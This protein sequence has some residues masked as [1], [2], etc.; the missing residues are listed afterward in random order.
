MN[1]LRSL[2]TWE[3]WQFL[4]IVLSMSWL[5]APSLNAHLSTKITFISQFEDA[6]QPWA[7]L[8]RLCD[9]LAAILL[10]LAVWA[11]Y[12]RKRNSA[13]DLSLY[14]PSLILLAIVALGSIIDVAFPSHCHGSGLVCL[15]PSGVSRLIHSGESVI[16]TLALLAVNLLWAVKKIPWARP[17]LLIQII[18]IVIFIVSQLTNQDGNTLTQFVYQVATAIW[19]A[20]IVPMLAGHDAVADRPD[21]RRQIALRVITAWILLGGFLAILSSIRNVEEISELSSAY[22]GNNTAWLS[23]HGVA[24]GIVLMY[25]SRHLWRGEYRAWQ[26]ASLLLWLETLKYA[27]ISPHTELTLLYG[28]TAAMLFMRRGLF[29]RMTSTE[30]LRDRLQK[31]AL[32]MIAVV[33]AL[34]VGLAAFRFKHHQDLDTLHISASHFFRHLFLVDA[35]NDLGP[36]PRRLLGQVLNVAGL[37]LLFAILISLFRPHKPLLPPANEHDRARLLNLLRTSSNSSED[38]FKYWPQPKS[39]FWS[40]DRESAV[41]YRVVGNVAFALADP[42]AHSNDVRQRTAKEFLDYCRRHGWRACFLMVQDDQQGI[43]KVHDYK[44]FRIGASAV[45]DVKEF[46]TETV[47]NKW[48]RWVLNKAKK[49]DWQYE[50]AMPPHDARL[51]SQLRHVSDIWL[52]RQNH[53]ERGFAL[54]YFDEAYLQACRLHLLRHDDELIAFANELPT[55]NNLPTA[56]IDLMRFLPD[57]DHAMPTLLAGTIQQLHAEGVKRK[58]DLGFVPLA[59]PTAR[60][61]QVVRRLGQSLMSESVSAQGLEQFKNKFAPAWANNYIAFDGDWIDL[62][63][64]SRQLDNLLEVL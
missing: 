10:G 32:V 29:D 38:Y 4:Y 36:M 49:Q 3:R 60:T 2:I 13:P 54:G 27:L 40:T 55:F 45:V 64:I 37:T 6:G 44:L 16:T 17:V 35:V 18:W 58:F 56:T 8:F 33:V 14:M 25:I 41:A 42:V 61:E 19:T 43:Y 57:R 47:R 46:S 48:W 39:Y 59:S 15:L 62:I 26:L 20:S 63:H 1:R 22:F 34:L 11:I 31:L 28:L 9:T 7:G 52:Q 24:V 5:L 12:R 23:Q 53:T 21:G 30:E 50:L 51:M